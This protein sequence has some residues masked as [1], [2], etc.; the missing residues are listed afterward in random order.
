MI[1]I[2]GYL[3]DNPNGTLSRCST[4]SLYLWL[5]CLSGH[6]FPLPAAV[7]RGPSCLPAPLGAI[8]LSIP[9]PPGS[10]LSRTCGRSSPHSPSSPRW[11]SSPAVRMRVFALL[12]CEC[13]SSLLHK[14]VARLHVSCCVFHYLKSQPYQLWA[15]G[16][17]F[18][19]FSHGMLQNIKCELVSCGKKL[20]LICSF[21]GYCE[22]IITG[23]LKIIESC[24]ETAFTYQHEQ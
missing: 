15:K 19:L 6:F 23:V 14:I 11:D 17:I 1:R 7:P 3:A 10:G 4:S 24:M 9:V 8:R 5:V 18:L 12:G 16:L 21:W 2:G 13:F 20:T 22:F